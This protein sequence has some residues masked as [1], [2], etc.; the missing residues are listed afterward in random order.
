MTP[1]VSKN[2]GLAPLS[3][4]LEDSLVL[5]PAEHGATLI[6]QKWGADLDPVT[7]QLVTLDY[8]YHGHPAINGVHQGQI[9]FQQ[10]LVQALL[11]DYQAVADD[12][13][14]ETAFGLYTP[15]AIG[16][17]IKLVAKVDEFAYQGSGNHRDYEGIYR[18]TDP[19]TYGP[20]TQL[21][22][23]PAA[24]KD[25]VWHLGYKELYQD[26][27]ARTLPSDTTIMGSAPYA[28][29]TS[30][31]TSFVMVAFLQKLESS[32]TL[33]G[34]QLALSAAGLAENEV[35]FSAI[36]KTQFEQRTQ[37]AGHVDVSLLV[38]YRYTARDLW[39]F[40]HRVSGLMLL[41]VPGNSSP[42]H[43]FADITA[44][45]TWI[46]EQ[47][48]AKEKRLAL[49]EHFNQ[50]D[51]NDG[52]FH[53]GVLTALEAMGEYPRQHH[54]SRES[55]FFN[56]DGYWNPDDYILLD[57]FP[58]AVDPFAEWV[59]VFKQTSLATAREAI[60][61][62]ADVNRANLAAAVT[63]VVDW[64]NRWGALAI[65]F[66]GGEGLLGL[67]GLIQAAQGVS[68]I[69]DAEN[70]DQVN[71]GVTRTVF[72]ALNALP[73]LIKGGIGLSGR[74]LERSPESSAVLSDNVVVEPET[75][76][77][78]EVVSSLPE[79]QAPEVFTPPGTQNVPVSQWTRPQLMRGFGRAVEGVSDETLEVIRQVSGVTDDQLRLQLTTGARP[80]GLLADTLLRFKT[81][82]RVQA[83]I[84]QLGSAE[85]SLGDMHMLRWL[86]TDKDWPAG[87]GLKL[88]DGDQVIWATGVAEEAA[89]VLTIQKK[90]NPF[91]RSV[92]R[93]LSEQNTR[94][95]L[96]GLLEPKAPYP[97][98]NVRARLLRLKAQGIVHDQRV[99]V[100]ALYY[101]K[102]TEPQSELQQL[103][104]HEYPSLPLSVRDQML[105]DQ[106]ISPD[107][108]L[109]LGQVK[110]LF[111]RMESQVQAYEGELRLARAY[112]GSYL[113]TV[114]N[115]DSHT[116]LLHSAQRMPGWNPR[117]S[118]TVREGSPIGAVL[119]RVGAPSLAQQRT[120]IQDAD[121]FLCL[122]SMP[123]PGY[124][125][126]DFADAIAHSLSD[127]ELSQ[128]GVRADDLDHFKFKLRLNLMG[129]RDF[130]T[131]L[132]RQQLRT[133]F[134]EPEEGGLR[135]GSGS[136]PTAALSA[137][138]MLVDSYIPGF[139][140]QQV[141][142]FMGC[143]DWPGEAQAE[144]QRI[145]ESQADLESCFEHWTS[146]DILEDDYYSTLNDSEASIDEEH[147]Q[148]W[149]DS[150]L[151]SR[152]DI[153]EKLRLLYTWRGP[154]ALKV[155]RDGR[156]IGFKFPS[157]FPPDDRFLRL[158]R[159]RLPG[160]PFV[161]RYVEFNSVVALSEPMALPKSR[162]DE[163][164]G[165]FPRLE[166]LEI[167]GLTDTSIPADV[168]KM[169]RLKHLKLTDGALQMV[170]GNNQLIGQL[171]ALESLDLSGNP[172]GVP[173]SIA[174]LGK[175]RNIRL[176]RTG[177]TAMPVALLERSTL[178]S[179]GLADNLITTIPRVVDLRWGLDLSGNPLSDLNSLQRL[180]AFRQETGVE[181]WI[182][183]NAPPLNQPVD[184][185]RG[186]SEPD[187]AARTALW[188]KVAAQ[189]QAA[190]AHITGY[191]SRFAKLSA[192]V[193]YQ[194]GYEGLRERLWLLLK[195]VAY[196]DE[197]LRI[198]MRG[199]N[200]DLAQVD[201]PRLL[202]ESLEQGILNYD[203]LRQGRPMFQLP[204]R[205]RLK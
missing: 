171:A 93:R 13:F 94:N 115:A 79:V 174:T 31:K 71:E 145:N 194:A 12:Q 83:Y 180:L 120:I 50:D 39:V 189:E 46:V 29:R 47:G 62:D 9:R 130:E 56:N 156:M 60:R 150:E 17:Q 113:E 99:S 16:P 157:D 10:S 84:V 5:T 92:A 175:L 2:N 137:D 178:E 58:N 88:M 200:R 190:D 163:Y 61:D 183:T 141:N 53:A 25:W 8:D 95:L 102:I 49:A 65:F 87:V 30:M 45:R 162:L 147:K 148:A 136:V 80:Q 104:A 132:R 20:S 131:V 72:G 185:L 7:T 166:T 40:R 197:S 198:R 74:A 138:R 27:L 75:S 144:L 55:G 112:E 103:L 186:L 67:A 168:A 91:F 21:A 101:Q 33:A 160:A 116:L 22:I 169:S 140:D 107:S 14:G 28:L 170:P 122:D 105:F 192:T 176:D 124:T 184:W 51:R 36:N 187:A 57:T 81:A 128:M 44:L 158:D 77:E 69:V 191:L 59:K 196:S 135:G 108:T 134:F 164:L 119:D 152:K 161:P 146:E 139:T 48:K 173:P 188:Q 195:R 66:P 204:K 90:N 165:C 96:G 1:S 43:Q 3:R 155:Y 133:P 78:P 37:P 89:D 202:L 110:A 64:I 54:L 86:A 70:R 26:Y 106:H 118:I 85:S 121:R 15:P 125:T 11:S 181:L 172:L 76:P 100:F 142:E 114:R 127:T 199:I 18:R 205:A 23:T 38:I 52:T 41:Y 151:I 109:T 35:E 203:A 24:Y 34:L 193:D 167:Q 143:F 111:Q 177:L 129:R 201:N 126:D 82:E 154:D 73:L 153:I 97:A 32:L 179:V 149:I 19:Q 42:V 4:A 68:E 159:P 98:I 117:L 123:S 6:R 182:S 63:P